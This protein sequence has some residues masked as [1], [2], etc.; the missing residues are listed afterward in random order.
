MKHSNEELRHKADN[1]EN[2]AKALSEKE[3]KGTNELL[4]KENN[5]LRSD[6][7]ALESEV[8]LQRREKLELQEHLRDER[9]KFQDELAEL[10]KRYP[11]KRIFELDKSIR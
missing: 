10:K 3:G 2:L 5:L 7:E 8:N 11:K 9:K 4:M 6:K 1:F